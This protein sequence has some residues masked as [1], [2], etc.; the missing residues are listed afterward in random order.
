MPQPALQKDESWIKKHM[1][2]KT[3]A[4]TDKM[5]SLSYTFAADDVNEDRWNVNH[6]LHS[7]EHIPVTERATVTLQEFK[8]VGRAAVS[9][10]PE[11]LDWL[12]NHQVSRYTY[13][14]LL[15]WC[16]NILKQIYYDS[17]YYLLV[18]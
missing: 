13:S 11:K 3:P 18:R 5:T 14:L 8:D 4:T 6:H 7:E 10:P 2:Q 17:D 12:L 9:Y 15:I 16:L 1:V